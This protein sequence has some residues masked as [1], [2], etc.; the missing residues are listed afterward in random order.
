MVASKPGVKGASP[1]AD[2]RQN[3]IRRHFAI[4]A[5]NKAPHEQGL[6]EGYRI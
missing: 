2:F 4:Q 6:V 1:F 3:A 5:N